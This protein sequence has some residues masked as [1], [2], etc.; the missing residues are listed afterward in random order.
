LT[1]EG[2]SD[3]DE[4][5]YIEDVDGP[6]T[7]RYRELR[8]M[9]RSYYARQPNT[10][11]GRWKN[12]GNCWNSLISGEPNVWEEAIKEQLAPLEGPR[13]I[14]R[15]LMREQLVDIHRYPGNGNISYVDMVDLD[16]GRLIRIGA[17]FVLDATETGEALPLAGAPWTIGQEPRY[18]YDEPDAPVEAHP[19]WV[20]SFTYCFDLRRT[21]GPLLNFP[22]M[23][24]DYVA[25]KAEGSYSLVYA[26]PPP[27]GD[28]LYRMFETVT[29]K[30][31][32]SFWAYR[33]IV[34]ASSFD[35]SQA[36]PDDISLINWSG[37]DFR[38]ASFIS[39]APLVELHVLTQARNYALGF[40]YWLR[41]ECPRDDGGFGYPELVP[42][43]DELGSDGVANYPYIRESRRLLAI[44]TLTE[45]DMVP[46]NG[47]SDTYPITNFFDTVGI[48][49]YPIDIHPALGEPPHLIETCPYEI[50][51]GAFIAR[52][53]PANLLPAAS[54]FGSSRLA[55][56]SARVHPIEWL[57]GEIAG[58]IAAFCIQHNIEPVA[59]RNDPVL[60]NELQTTL[61]NTGI[62]ITWEKELI[63]SNLNHPPPAATH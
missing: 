49:S 63:K 7:R 39:R 17:R 16:T 36:Y 59:I 3:P 61:V 11:P 42:A 62:N 29:N 27:R 54:D 48:A 4:N 53:G 44:S 12:I 55:M 56:A 35:N 20:Q 2:V 46:R 40:L 50:P 43:A 57:A 31:Y 22:A 38:G 41:T 33:R 8:Q 60:L 9:V 13:A 14:R 18:E 5:Q 19:E 52:S 37:N 47:Q 24:E 21:R 1:G 28:V 30:E 45:N 10:L 25:N 6:G 58:N 32:G 26:Y 51:L 34:A 23:P 15:I